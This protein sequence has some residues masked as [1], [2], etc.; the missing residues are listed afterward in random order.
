MQES[1]TSGPLGGFSTF[2]LGSSGVVQTVGLIA[3]FTTFNNTNIDR[4]EWSALIRLESKQELNELCLAFW[5]G[6]KA[7]KFPVSAHL[8]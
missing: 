7:S 3:G 1:Q 6:L 5:E 8:F 4:L 2:K